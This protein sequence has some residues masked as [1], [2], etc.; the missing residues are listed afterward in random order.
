M[1]EVVD[2]SGLRGTG[3]AITAVLVVS[4]TNNHGEVAAVVAVAPSRNRYYYYYNSKLLLL[5]QWV[6]LVAEDRPRT[7]EQRK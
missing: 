1:T 7:V 2:S 4:R 6:R 5:S 3:N